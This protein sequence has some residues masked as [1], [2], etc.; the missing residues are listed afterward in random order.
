MAS[1]VILENMAINLD[2]VTHVDFDVDVKG[3][4]SIGIMLV[5]NRTFSQYDF[6]LSGVEAENFLLKLESVKVGEA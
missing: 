2:Q 3:S 1:F 5:G 6:V 4:S